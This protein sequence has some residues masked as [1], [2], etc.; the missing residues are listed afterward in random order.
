MSVG[1]KLPAANEPVADTTGARSISKPHH[2]S[3]SSKERQHFSSTCH[4]YSRS[5]LSFSSSDKPRNR[6]ID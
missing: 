4:H 6:R 3:S 1:L 2:H 5:N